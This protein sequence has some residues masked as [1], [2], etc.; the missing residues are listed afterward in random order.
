MYGNLTN[1]ADWQTLKDMVDGGT[2]VQLGFGDGMD[3][4]Y[5]A[6][7]AETV[8]SLQQS[9]HVPHIGFAHPLDQWRKILEF[10]RVSD[11]VL[12]SSVPV[13]QVFDRLIPKSFTLAVVDLAALGNIGVEAGLTAGLHC[14]NTVAIHQPQHWAI[15]D[16]VRRLVG[17]ELQ[18]TETPGLYVI[19]HRPVP[20]PARLAEGS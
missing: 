12:Y 4:A 10:Y 16:A 2:V 1:A 5:L 8:V 15:A 3:T 9:E 19:H 17:N 7:E 14:A 18:L 13:A 11:R 20:L 6:Q